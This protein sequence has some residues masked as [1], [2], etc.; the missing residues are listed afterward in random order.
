MWN[1][2]KSLALSKWAVRFFLAVLV[3][4]DLGGYWIVKWF[5]NFSRYEPINDLRHG[6]LF[7]VT[8][9]AAS[10]PA[11]LILYCLYRLLCNIG[12]GE[13]FIL[14]NVK[15]LRASSWCCISAALICLA[16]S[17]YYVPFL[18]ICVAA[19]FMALIIRIIKN[20]FEQALLMKAELDLTV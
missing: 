16:S 1:D 14:Q 10:I 8:L 20:V 17:F 9:Y 19:A 6:I 4:F 7:M 2:Q 13:I 11:Y 3:T 18:A 12:E 15:A 5:I